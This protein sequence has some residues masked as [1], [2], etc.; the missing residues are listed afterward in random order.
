MNK[1]LIFLIIVVIAIA[2]G[3]RKDT[4]NGSFLHFKRFGSR[5]ERFEDPKIAEAFNNIDIECFKENLQMDKFGEKFVTEIE[6]DVLYKQATL[7]CHEYAINEFLS[8]KC[9]DRGGKLNFNS[10][11][12]LINCFKAK[13]FELEPTSKLI[14]E[15][16]HDVIK[17]CNTN[18]INLVPNS[19]R[20]DYVNYNAVVEQ[21]TC[22]KFSQND[23]TIIFLKGFLIDLV[24]LDEVV[25]KTEA[26]E[27]K[28]KENLF[29]KHAYDCI[30]KRFEDE[31]ANKL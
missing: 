21:L 25:K 14:S 29:I 8:Y 22:G 2:H 28:E 20:N 11:T 19:L 26:K 6:Q 10:N 27:I 7:A 12:K 24:D 31:D 4:I 9:N 30:I 23:F 15:A 16:D 3:A 5:P 17:S 13:L 18:F 1:I